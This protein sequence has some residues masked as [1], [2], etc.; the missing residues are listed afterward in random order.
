MN[1][2][3]ENLTIADLRKLH[4]QY[5]NQHPDQKTAVEL[6]EEIREDRK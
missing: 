5:K 1:T 3:F 6:L 4:E 2:E